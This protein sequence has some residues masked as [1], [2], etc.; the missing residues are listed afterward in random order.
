MSRPK[1]VSA[2]LDATIAAEAL[3]GVKAKLA[4]LRGDG[5]RLEIRIGDGPVLKYTPR[6]EA[7]GCQDADPPW[8]Q[9]R[10]SSASRRMPKTRNAPTSRRAV[11]NSRRGR[12]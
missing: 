2:A 12:S 1:N 9:L 11:Q 3:Q 10:G 7:A 8:P 5:D 4:E 6:Q